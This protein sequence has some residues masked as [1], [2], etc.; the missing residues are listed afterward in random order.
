VGSCVAAGKT[1]EWEDLE[2]FPLF[3]LL[4]SMM[5]LL[6]PSKK[7]NTQAVGFIFHLSCSISF[8]IQSSL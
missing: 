6:V 1:Q 7:K 4:V 5:T 2:R 8:F 3:I